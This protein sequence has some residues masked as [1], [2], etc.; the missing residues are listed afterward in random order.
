MMGNYLTVL[1]QLPVSNAATKIVNIASA[2]YKD[3]EGNSLE[4]ISPAVEI[5]VRPVASLYVT[6]D[7]SNPSEVVAANQTITRKFQICNTSNVA[8]FYTIS[9]TGI[10]SPSEITALYFD[11]DQNGIVSAGDTLTGVNSINSPS[12]EIGKCIGVLAIVET[13]NISPGDRLTI[14][15][16]ARSNIPDAANGFVEDSGTIINTAG[17]SVTFTDPDDPTLIPS[18]LVENKKTYISTRSETLDYAIAFRNNGEVPAQNVTVTDDLPAELT[19]VSNSLRVDNASVTDSEDGDP[20]SVSGQRLTVRMANPVQPGQAVRV[21]FQA[22][23]TGATVPGRGIVNIARIGALNTPTIETSQAIAVVDPFGTV[24]AARGAAANPIANAVVKISTDQAGANAIGIPENQG[25]DP[26]LTNTNP[27]TT[28]SKGRFSFGL[29]PD[30]LGSPTAPAV[31]YVNVSADGFKSRVMQISLIPGGNGL[32]KMSVKSLDGMPLAVAGGFELTVNDVDIQ[33]IA[34]IAYNIPLFEDA[35]LQVTKTADRVQAQI[36][37]I[38]TYRVEA[39]NSSIAPINDLIVTDTLPDS[40]NYAENST[41]IVRGSGQAAIEPVITNGNVL[42]FR[43]GQLNSG[44]RLTII[45]RVRVGVNARNGD[46]YNSAA[47]RG[48]F[49]SGEI[50]QSSVSRVGV[51]VDGGVFSMQQFIIGRVYVDGN[52]NNVFDKGEKPVVGARLY[53]ANGESVITDSEGLYNLPAVSQGAQV[54]SVDPITL[55]QGYL[56]ADNNTFAGKSWS[57]LLRTPLGGGAMLRQNFAL[58]PSKTDPPKAY[59]QT[60]DEDANS[61]TSDQQ[62]STALNTKDI[63]AD[64]QD[65]AI[66]YNDKT[67]TKSAGTV[68]VQPILA[69]D[70][71]IQSLNENQ[72]IMFPALNLEAAVAKDW[73]TVVKINNQEVGSQNIG[74]TREDK[75]NQITTYTYIG[76]GLKP[77][78]NQISVTA[79]SP[80]GE[81]GKTATATV[82]GRGAAKRLEIITDKKELEASGRDSAKITV[83]AYDEWNNPAQDTTVAVQTSAGRLIK[84]E[85]YADNRQAAKNNEIA[86]GKDLQPTAGITAEQINQPM[87]QQE[88]LLNQGIGIVKLIGDT[89]IGAAHLQAVSGEAKAETDVQFVSELRSGILVSLAEV[90]VGKNAPEMTNRGTNENVRSHIQMFFKGSLFGTKN[91]LT[92]A[93]DSQ[94]PLNRLNGR[95]RLFQLN[96]LDRVYPVFGDSSTRFQET[97]SNSKVYARADRGRSY[98]MFGDFD[99]DM[100]RN[101]LL[102]Y[103]RRLTGGKVFLGNDRGDFL[104]VT[105]A[106]PDTSFARQIIPGG[107]LGIVQLGYYDILPGSEVLT[108]EVRDRRNPESIISREILTRGLDYNLDTQ[109]GTI[110][111]L[112]PIPTFDRLLNLVQIV[113]TYEYRSNGMESSVYTGRASKNIEPLGLRLGLSYIDQQQANSPAFRLGGADLSLKLPKNGRLDAE[114]AMS[115]GSLNTGFSFF[116]NRPNGN[117]YN[118][119]A[120]F[121]SAEQPISLG[122]SVL[123]FEGITSSR[124][125]YN[126]FGSTVAPGN[127]RG[128]LLLETKPLNNAT[129]RLNLSGEKN[130]TENVDNRRATAGIHWTQTINEKLNVDVGYDFR[131]FSDSNADK[132]INSNLITVGADFKPTEKLSF[133]IK[134]EQNLGDADPTYPSQTIMTADYQVKEWAKLFFAQRLSSAPI[135]PISDVAGTGFAFSQ[136]RNETAVGVET[137]FGKFTSMS[138]RYQLENGLNGTDSFAVVGLQNRLP[139]NKVLS[140]DLGY[141]RALHLAGE[142]QSYNNFLVGANYLPN[143]KFRS[144]FRYELRDRDGLGQVLSFGAAGEIKKGWTMLGRYQF[145]DISYNERKSE[146]TDGQIAFAVRPHDTD[147]YGFL[148]SYNRRSSFFSNN[149]LNSNDLPTQL[150]TDVISADGFHQTTRRLELYGRFAFKF[151]S[152]G[153]SDLPYASNLTYLLQGRAQYRLTRRFD[154]ALEDRYLYQPSS[155]SQRNWLGTELGFWATPDLRFGAGYNFSRAQE[156]FGFNSNNVFNKNGFYFVISSKISRLFDLFGTSKK[157]LVSEED[158]SRINQPSQKTGNGKTN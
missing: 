56:L 67:E 104:S 91:M 99:A 11:T 18:K 36:G 132:V 146:V 45:Y 85:E 4:T 8:D 157:G 154:V 93:Y 40:F 21:S 76:L 110:F 15:I 155:G 139:V 16:T 54:I 123:K 31:Y 25:F 33:S 22:V 51:R 100:E 84:P 105:G 78:P 158:S 124:E 92:L 152:D 44:E 111:F 63:L 147:K 71:K 62:K 38:V 156:P 43:V 69:G 26:N 144:S 125:F 134:R 109:S 90:S 145:G 83:R 129:V 77:G 39:N 151:G 89:K 32:F 41:K 34:D 49:P 96:P 10:G 19:Y 116:G 119:N 97:E 127:T 137:K 65:V 9:K 53:L 57:R 12:V 136:A 30:Q 102:G 48:K 153:N 24:F 14:G 107:T 70:V 112:R 121:V 3:D 120:F 118:G 59:D 1:P 79:I 75:Q 7:E 6:P 143:D 2:T 29:R 20:A 149:E 35:T 95:D 135:T 138:G 140:L 68:D 5:T 98:A 113:A 72:V 58:V 114:W 66:E 37:D 61:F 86:L 101:R 73:K 142:G 150:K 122:R 27:Y 133:G 60:Q 17:K 13:K 94:Q 74:T 55:P 87:Q 64:M 126:P 88:I 81:T 50:V 46:N 52:G 23:I 148:F 82:Y 28:D 117:E 141:E 128:T 42:Q 108:I 130:S 115:R 106:R 103:T 80:A 47:G 131:R